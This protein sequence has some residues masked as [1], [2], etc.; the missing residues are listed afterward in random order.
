M[1]E[2]RMEME[3]KLSVAQRIRGPVV[4]LNVC[5]TERGEVDYAAMRKY[6]NWLCEQKVPVLRLTYGSSEFYMLSDKQLWRLTAEL[7]QAIAGRAVF[8]ASTGFWPAKVTQEFL[9]HAE[10]EG[11]DAVKVQTNPILMTS[12]LPVREILVDYYDHIQ[13]ASTIPLI[14]WA[15]PT[16][17]YPLDVVAEL[18]QRPQIV[19]IKNDDDAFYYYYD[20]IRRT[21]EED[22]AVISGGMMRNFMLGYQVGSA[23]YLCTVAPFRPDIALAFYD[24]LVNRQFDEAWQMVFRFED[25]W[26]KTAGKLGWLQSIKSAIS[27]HGLVPND[28]IG[29]PSMSHDDEKRAEIRDCLAQVFGSIEKVEL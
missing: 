5:F 8:I 18:A 1:H 26:I 10:A 15:H 20:L 6:V 12:G 14:L 21:A 19:G 17:P 27:L 24:R 22:F 2:E 7:A 3:T 11:V 23:A 25:P 28:L 13:K 29:V 4:P 16:G 9:Q